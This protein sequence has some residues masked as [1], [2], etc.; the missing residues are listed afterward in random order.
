VRRTQP[1]LA[2]DFAGQGEFRII[3]IIAFDNK[4]ILVIAYVFKVCAI[5][6]IAIKFRAMGDECSSFVWE[7]SRMDSLGVNF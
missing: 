7:L 1:L 4:L 6:E 5:N 3:Q 2:F